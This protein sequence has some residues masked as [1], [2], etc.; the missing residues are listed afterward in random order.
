MIAAISWSQPSARQLRSPVALALKV[1]TIL[2]S[3]ATHLVSDFHNETAKL[4][5]ALGAALA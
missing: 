4:G 5:Q 2:L 1:P 3:R